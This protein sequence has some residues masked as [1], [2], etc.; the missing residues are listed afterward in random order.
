MATHCSAIFAHITHSLGIL[1][2]Q[3]SRSI[4]E[5]HSAKEGA[6]RYRGPT[7]TTLA[8]TTDMI[9]QRKNG[10]ISELYSYHHR[11]RTHKKYPA[12]RSP[13]KSTSINLPW[14]RLTD[15]LETLLRVANSA[16]SFKTSC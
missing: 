5:M 1:V 9:V 13:K 10:I 15:P 8:Q 3:E 4:L 12:H 16:R 6:G 2:S 11:V 7:R 14:E